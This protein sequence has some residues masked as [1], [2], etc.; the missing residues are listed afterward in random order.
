[1]TTDLKA[2]QGGKAPARPPST[3]VLRDLER[4][5]LGKVLLDP[6]TLASVREVLEPGDLSPQGR[7]VLE[8]LAEQHEEGFPCSLAAVLDDLDRAGNLE[9]VGGAAAVCELADSEAT[10]VGVADVA[11]RLRR[12][13]LERKARVLAEQIARGDRDATTREELREIE[14]QLEGVSVGSLD[15]AA[16]GFSGERLEALRKRPVR[17]SPFAKLLPP[18][19]GLV[20]FNAKPKTGK[21]TLAGYL[22]QAWACGVSPWEGAP[23]LPGSRALVLSA[24]QPVERVDATLRRLDTMS[25]NVTREKWT[26]RVTVV[27]RDPELP[28]NAARMLTL[29]GTGRALLRQGLLRARREGDPYGLVVLDS[30]SR[31][32]PENLDENSNA[33]VSAWLAPLQELAEELGVYIVLIHHVGHAEGRNEARTAGRGASAIAAVAQGLWLLENADDPRQRRLHVQGNALTETRLTF[34]V[35]GE[36][37]EPGE[38]LYWRPADPLDSYD[39]EELVGDEEITTGELAARLQDPPLKEGERAGGVAQRLAAA[40]RNEW[41]KAGLIEVREGKRRSKLLRRILH[42]EGET[43]EEIL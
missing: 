39:L 37:N 18:E 34:Q 35:A 41:Q 30:M 26:E 23:A 16:A 19:P 43:E 28:R 4:A 24:E 29:D 2:I 1:M 9:L 14:E 8:V 40:L 3:D 11:R 25:A 38:I 20:V 6:S 42:D 10:A 21:T 13:A 36:E 5:L 15:L 17:V 12:L 27:A 22:A 31:L 7:A 33:E 32:V